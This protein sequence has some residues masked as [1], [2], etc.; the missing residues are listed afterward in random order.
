LQAIEHKVSGSGRSKEIART[1]SGYTDWCI[2]NGCIA[3]PASYESVGGY[4]CETVQ[5]LDGSAKSVAN[6]V[7]A[8]KVFSH[9][10]KLPWLDE[11]ATYR[12]KKIRKQLALDD[13]V[14]IAR[15]HPIQLDMIHQ[16]LKGHWKVRESE[17]EMLLATVFLTAHNGLLRGGEYLGADHPLRPQ[18]FEWEFRTRSVTISLGPTKTVRTGVGANVRITDY[19]GPSAYKFLLRWFNQNQLWGRTECFVFPRRIRATKGAPERLDFLQSASVRWFDRAVEQ[20]MTQLGHD[21]S[22]YSCHSFRA[23]GATDLF[24]LGVPYPKI[25][26][27]GRFEIRSSIDLL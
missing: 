9:Y 25:K 19:E 17:Y 7:S 2:V 6:K 26:Q 23:G 16:L 3:F 20:A 12:L 15:K 4:I 27:Y 1:A 18:H 10:L 5:D 8:L 13:D 21:A 14:A 24:I 11:A 22:L